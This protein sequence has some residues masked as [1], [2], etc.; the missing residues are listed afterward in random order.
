MKIIGWWKPCIKTLKQ[1]F[2]PQRKVKVR[3]KSLPWVNGSIRKLVNQ[4]Y[5]FLCKFQKTGDEEDRKRYKSLR[6]E[7]NRA[8]RKAEAEY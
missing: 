4:R 7:V 5:K 3:R 8:M 6:N 2:L 1:I